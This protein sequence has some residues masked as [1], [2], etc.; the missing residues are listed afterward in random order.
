MCRVQF[1]GFKLKVCSIVIITNIYI[2]LHSHISTY[3]YIIYIYMYIYIYVY[4][5][6]G[7]SIYLYILAHNSPRSVA[8]GP[9]GWSVKSLKDFKIAAFAKA[10][11]LGFQGSGVRGFG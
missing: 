1:L 6:Y 2:S 5:E 3:V 8:L 4:Y 7:S 9:R 11:G 10:A